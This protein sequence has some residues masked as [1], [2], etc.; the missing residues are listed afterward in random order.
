MTPPITVQVAA[1]V[2]H[3]SVPAGPDFTG[4]IESVE[5]APPGQTNLVNDTVVVVIVR[6]SNRGAPS[7]VWNWDME[8]TLLSGQRIEPKKFATNIPTMLSATS[9]SFVL[10]SG[11]TSIKMDSSTLL[12]Y[13]LGQTPLET[14]GA[15]E[16]W[17]AFDFGNAPV[18][19]LRRPGT[20]YDL[21]LADSTGK[22][23]PIELILPATQ[24]YPNQ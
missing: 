5:W 16:G 15:R 23:F 24:M 10:A 17:V 21:K 4:Y 12:P 8:I 1:P 20:I 2:G 9:A 11:S 22:I 7:I 18:D 6:I 19:E 13:S 14:G 3:D